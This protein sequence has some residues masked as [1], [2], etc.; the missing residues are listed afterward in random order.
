MLTADRVFFNGNLLTQTSRTPTATAM[1][2]RRGEILFV[3]GDRDARGLAGAATERVDLG[4]KT[5]VPGFCD[6]HLH[7]AS[8]GLNLARSTDI[9]DAADI[10]ELGERLTAQR[11]RS[12]IEWVLGRGFDQSKLRE[13]RFPTRRELDRVSSSRPL[14]ITRICGHAAVANSAA[15]ALLSDR[16]RAA[17]DPETGLY[18]EGDIGAFW[19]YVPPPTPNEMEQAI[20]RAGRV[21]LR[22]GITS[23]G[24]LIDSLDQMGAYQRLHREGK[25]PVRVTMMPPYRA[26]AAL[27]EH[28]I[29]TGFG[30]QWL[31]FGGAKLFSDGSLG[32]RTALLASPYT[33]DP[34]SA[35][36]LGLRIYDPADLKAKAA[37]A[38]AKGFQL[39]IHAIGDQ[40]NR[41]TL[42][43]IEHALG[44]GGDNTF[45]RHRIEH[46]SILP[47]DLLQRM[48]DRGILA[49]VQ[50]QF[51]QSDT[52]TG[53][54]VGPERASW[55]YPFR[56]MRR[57]GIPLALSS[58]C[59]VEKLDA[60]ACLDAAINRAAWSPNECLT[61]E[62]ALRDYTFG[63][64]YALHNE[65]HLGTLEA[66]KL[67]DFVV[68]S[69]DPTRSGA[70][71][72]AIKAEQV[73]LAG[74]A[75]PAGD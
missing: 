21:A 61:A 30:D 40:A 35:F 5:V 64:A 43:A 19:K 10:G 57:A 1:A 31:K 54:R 62:D 2:T 72:R 12:P 15:I 9:T 42:D 25:L 69:G 17:G 24:T 39:V 52:W 46:A 63:S 55:T 26:V 41:E 51:V 47:P 32:A 8:F 28:G 74:E 60:F 73:Y 71:L 36:N 34:D 65:T 49:V 33:D 4:G 48:A 13:N 22:T 29:G 37:D 59:P 67:A 68:L 38:Q 6:A 7:F 27:H 23:V 53:E 66:G 50:P 18:T 58:D 75:V 44:P 11:E 56:T 20:L 45:H 70:D 16:E 14:L 3:G